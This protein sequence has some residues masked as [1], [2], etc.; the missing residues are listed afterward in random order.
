MDR[1]DSRRQIA[2]LAWVLGLLLHTGCATLLS[3]KK[4]PVAIDNVNGSTYFSVHD[5]NNELVYQGVTPQQVTLDAK[6]M[7]F[8][9]A[10]YKVVFAGDQGRTQQSEIRAS[11]DPWTAGNIVVGG[12]VGLAV[13]GFTGA[14]FKLPKT[15]NGTVPPQ[16]AVTDID[17]GSMLA[18]AAI[19]TGSGNEAT[20]AA[21]PPIS[22]PDVQTATAIQ[23]QD[24]AGTIWR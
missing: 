12:V 22:G 23:S 3:D 15:L 14:M 20:A 8:W 9:P 4:Y 7:P 10:K 18:R 13:D 6:S 17:Q 16:Y 5:R 1:L 24:T 11:F 2:A 19:G 21:Q